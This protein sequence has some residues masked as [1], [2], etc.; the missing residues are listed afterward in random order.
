MDH[1]GVE[2][3]AGTPLVNLS[4]AGPADPLLTALVT[5]GLKRGVIFVAA[6][7]PRRVRIRAR[8]RQP[9]G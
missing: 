9:T 8:R 4:L 6:S 2:L 1:A 7:A 3:A 5:N